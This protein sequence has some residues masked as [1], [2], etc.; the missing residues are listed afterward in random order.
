MNLNM[1]RP[2]NETEDLLLSITKN[3][4]TLIEQTHR[5]AEETLE[6]KMDKP[7]ET[8]HFKPQIQI[9]GDW[10]LGLVNLEV[11]IST[12]NITEANN[13]FEIYRD[14]SNKFGFLEL[15]DKLEEILNIPHITDD[16]LNDEVLGPR[17]ID[18]Y[19]K[20]S[21]EEKNRDGYMVLLFGYSA[22]SF[23]D[24]ESYLRL[25]IGLDEKDIQLILKEYNS[26]FITYELS[27][28]I[29]TIK[30][31]SDAIQTF[32]GHEGTIQLEYDDISMRATI[33]LKF[34]SK[35]TMFALG[36]LRFDKQS[37]FHTLLGFS[38]YWDYKPTNSSH[39]LISGVYPSDKI[40]LNLN[41]I[42]KIH[43]KCD[44]IDGSI[45]N[46][47]RQPILY[48]FVL[49]KPSG[50][51]VFCESE[52]IHYKKINKSVLNTIT[53]YLEDANNKEVNFNQETLTFTLQMIK[54]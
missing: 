11:Y 54:I 43:L 42:D 22:S 17:I 40:I 24:F 35:Q 18:E 39:V 3:C 53:F 10:M 14:M 51:K 30:D 13:K 5:K 45:Q 47:E 9:H 29:Y 36:T 38:P 26:H 25:V 23:R 48:S 28:G 15:K 34:K 21:T 16:H 1:I 41:T 20:L 12:F 27:P 7:R 46:G 4:Q 8:F 19:I 33:V 6:F 52:S 37:F 32:S 2:K 50:Y 49:D 44:C 31:I